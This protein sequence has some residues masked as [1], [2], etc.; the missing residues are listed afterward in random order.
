MAANEPVDNDL[1]AQLAV[2]VENLNFQP[3]EPQPQEQAA[4]YVKYA[5]GMDG[6]PLQVVREEIHRLLRVVDGRHQG[7]VFKV[8]RCQ[9]VDNPAHIEDRWAVPAAEGE[10]PELDFDGVEDDF[11]EIPPWDPVLIEAD[12]DTYAEIH[13]SCHLPLPRFTELTQT[14]KNTRRDG[15]F[16]DDVAVR[17]RHCGRGI[18]SEED[19]EIF[20]YRLL[21]PKD[22]LEFTPWT[23]VDQLVIN[24]R[25]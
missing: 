21:H 25:T 10:Q 11:R 24:Y 20:C 9:L 6:E 14:V 18:P 1:V 22:N 16:V 17:L 3:A 4:P 12:D 8:N 19:D 2:G 13:S 7:V 5:T 15:I 23:Q